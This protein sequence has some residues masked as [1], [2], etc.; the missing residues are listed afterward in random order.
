MPDMSFAD[1]MRQIDSYLIKAIGLTHNDL[2]NHL[3]RDEYENDTDPRDVA[4]DVIYDNASE[5]GM[6]MDDI[7]AIQDRLG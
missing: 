7:E 3:Y 5:M 6:S 4:S 1:Y 2:K